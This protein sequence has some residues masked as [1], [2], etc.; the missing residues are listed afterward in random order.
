MG[1]EWTPPACL[2]WE[3]ET[4]DLVLAVAGSF[5]HASG[6]RGLLERVAAISA[7]ETVRYWSV[8]RK[9]WRAL[10]TEAYALEGPDRRRRRP[11]FS[12]DELQPGHDL[13]FWQEVNT[14][15]STGTYRLR[16]RERSPRRLVLELENVEA[17][18]FLAL[19]ALA[20]GQYRTLFFLDQDTGSVWRYY[21]LTRIGAAVGP[22]ART[23]EA[24]YVNRA[25][26]I[27]R[28]FAGLPT[29]QEPPAAP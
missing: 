2:G 16:I 27:Y 9:R 4:P 3:S 29:D 19:Y 1:D 11:D 8:T 12:V 26:A 14:P 5:Y 17:M 22:L 10:V 13:Y 18:D 25:V 24:S 7:L 23:R 21:S 6:L 20:P 28:H 15:A